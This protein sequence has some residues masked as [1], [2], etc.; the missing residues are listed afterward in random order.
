M[1][2]MLTSQEP[3]TRRWT[4]KE[5]YQLAE[6]GLFNGQRAELIE[7]EI[8]VLSPQKWAHASCVDRVGE[9]LRLA[10][11]AGHWVR[12]Q[13]LLN[14]NVHSDPEP[15]VSVVKGGRE[16]YSDHPTSALLTVEVS[17]TTLDFDRNEK[18]SLYA[19]AGI[20]DYWIE[21]LVDEQVEM[22]RQPGPDASRPHKH[23]YAQVTVL[24]R[25]DLVNPLA[26]PQVSVAVSN[27]LS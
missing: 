16:D 27:L 22:H 3:Q 24:K 17:D 6:L 14:L 19:L 5:F 1:T 8:M 4:R 9:A 11:G 21:N 2:Q 15:D 13:L 25:G 12:T 26:V 20:A 23:G 10:L 7:G 18:A